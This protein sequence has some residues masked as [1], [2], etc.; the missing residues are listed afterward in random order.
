MRD[1]EFNCLELVRIKHAL[2][3]AQLEWSKD[4]RTFREAGVESMAQHF[5]RYAQDA[6]DILERFELREIAEVR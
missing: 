1:F 3:V 2:E 5:D 4:A 6:A